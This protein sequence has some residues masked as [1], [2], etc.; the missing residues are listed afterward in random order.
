GKLLYP[1][2]QD[3]LNPGFW[4]G[5]AKGNFFGMPKTPPGMM[6]VKVELANPVSSMTV[7]FHHPIQQGGTNLLG[8]QGTPF[9]PKILVKYNQALTWTTKGNIASDADV[10]VDRQSDGNKMLET[11]TATFDVPTDATA[12]YFQVSNTGD[13]DGMYGD[14]QVE[15][16]P[17]PPMDMP[18]AGDAGG[19]MAMPT[20]SNG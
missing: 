15:S 12:V 3:P 5:P 2:K 13:Q 6:Q 7:T 10:T 1:K 16:T 9:T 18:D 14:F 4:A 19:P 8:M 20:N 17:V 11:F